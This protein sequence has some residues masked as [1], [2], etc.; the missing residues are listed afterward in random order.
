MRCQVCGAE[1]D[2]TLAE[3][4]PLPKAL[5]FMEDF[6]K[7]HEHEAEELFPYAQCGDLSNPE[8]K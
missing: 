1:S 4:N 6:I 5:Q 8:S 2:A 7:K 3:W